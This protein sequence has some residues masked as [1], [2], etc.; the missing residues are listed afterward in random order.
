MKAKDILIS[1]A[2][3]VAAGAVLFLARTALATTAADNRSA[4]A[5]EMMTTLLPG[6]ETFTAE[7]YT[8]ED[9]NIS[10]VWKGET[11]YVVESVVEGYAGEITVW[12][13]VDNRGAV[14]GLVVRDMGETWG[15][16]R[17]A[18]TDLSFLDQF[19]GTAGTAVVGE[20]V[21]ALTGATVT[22]KAIAKAVNSASAFVTGADTSTSATEWG[23]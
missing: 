7:A 6:G 15:L 16:G 20:G 2:V 8:G 13:G 10:A 11:G 18:L 14:T 1:A 22:S 17:R 9:E 21:D 23:G 3:I 19:V 4:E 5:R 12:T